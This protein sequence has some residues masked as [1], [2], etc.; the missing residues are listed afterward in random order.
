[1]STQQ[2]YEQLLAAEPAHDG[3]YRTWGIWHDW[4]TFGRDY[5]QEHPEVGMPATASIGSDR[6]AYTVT[7]VGKGRVWAKQDKVRAL[8]GN[9]GEQQRYLYLPDSLAEE[10]MFVFSPKERVHKNGSYRLRLGERN[11]YRDPSF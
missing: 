5:L 9:D 4:V 6:S 11:A 3:D 8:P 10:R 1:M 2:R 7:R